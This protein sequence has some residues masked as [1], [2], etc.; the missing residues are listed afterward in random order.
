MSSQN[1]GAGL[2]KGPVRPDEAAAPPPGKGRDSSVA[3]ASGAKG[4]T[5]R[6]V[7]LVLVITPALIFFMSRK[8]VGHAANRPESRHHVLEQ[9][10]SSG[11]FSSRVNAMD[12][13]TIDYPGR[14]GRARA[15][16]SLTRYDYDSDP[17]SANLVYARAM[18]FAG[19]Y[20]SRPYWNGRRLEVGMP[21]DRG[22]ADLAI[23]HLIPCESMGKTINRVDSNGKMSYGILQFQD[24]D[25]WEAVSGLGGNPDNRDD[26]IRM[27]EWAVEN[28]MIN[29]WTCAQILR[30]M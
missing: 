17:R 14:T 2:S 8:D 7:L 3:R 20:D 30:M 9:W 18:F 4:S 27:A 12:R 13:R 29:H 22:T 19:R 10:P 11:L 1:G 15:H 16:S 28:G 24:W 6:R 5:G 25:E 21:T 26:A 23:E